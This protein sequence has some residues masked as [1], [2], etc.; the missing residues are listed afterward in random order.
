MKVLKTVFLLSLAFT[1]HSFAM[2]EAQFP[3]ENLA[4]PNNFNATL[5]QI[6]D[7]M[8]MSNGL[9][10][11]NALLGELGSA[12]S[13][14]AVR[15]LLSQDQFWSTD[16][17]TRQ[18]LEHI[19]AFTSIQTRPH[20]FTSYVHGFL[21]WDYFNTLVN[22]NKNLDNKDL[23][24]AGKTRIRKVVNNPDV[25]AKINLKLNLDILDDTD[26]PFA[27]ELK[28]VIGWQTPK[29]R[30]KVYV[31]ALLMPMEVFMMAHKKVFFMPQFIMAYHNWS[32]MGLDL[33]S[34]DAADAYIT[35]N[36][37][38]VVFEIDTTEFPNFTTMIQHDEG[39]IA[40]KPRSLLSCL[41]AFAW[42]GLRKV[43]LGSK[44]IAVIS[45]KI[46]DNALVSTE[47]KISLQPVTVPYAWVKTKGRVQYSRAASAKVLLHNTKTLFTSFTS[48]ESDNNFV[49][50]STWANYDFD[51][52]HAIP[53]G[54]TGYEIDGKNFETLYKA[55]ELAKLSP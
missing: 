25:L 20:D 49:K 6:E 8:M 32:D 13:V 31:P 1:L 9:I 37:H 48:K 7:Q 51:K 44:E 41:N 53:E 54:M 12:A 38:N 30:G 55:Q 29:W 52:S 36:R 21:A 45:L 10:F 17:V 4:T 22:Y 15:Y 39:G 23:W 28:S 43:D 3:L 16:N 2:D 50:L 26:G 35:N 5:V 18:N 14:D 27:K 34:D 33:Y 46:V 24:E 11:S 40:G 42:L 19:S 47:G